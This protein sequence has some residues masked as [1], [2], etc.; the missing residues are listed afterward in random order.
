MVGLVLQ[1]ADE[2]A[3]LNSELE[4]SNIELDSFAYVASHDLKEPLRGIHNYSS[5]LI[6][7][8]GDQLDED[9][10]NKLNTL[11][12]L[13]QRMENLINSLLHY[14]RLGRAELTIAPVDLQALV[15]S[16]IEVI[17]IS[18]SEAITFR[19]AP[20]LP[21][22]ECD[23]TQVTELFTNLMTNAIKYNTSDEKI[24]EIGYEQ[25]TT[26]QDE[27]IPV[28]ANTPADATVF[29]V[30]DNGIGIRPKHLDMVFRIFKRLHAQNRYGGGT[31]A[32]LTI[33]KK[34]VERHGGQIWVDS[35]YG[36]GSTF[37][38]TLKGDR[39]D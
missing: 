16:A 31:G 27:Q 21:V 3:Q 2:L 20:D 9:G 32:G 28:P 15:N 17:K 36:E 5:F 35:V 1:K 30:R 8:Y 13:T 24:V 25:A 39:Y 14:S 34:I 37:Y 7:D 19:V 23:R 10:V 26:L 18:K 11:M 6:E 12:R 22:T 29:Y 33:V 38:F 4:R